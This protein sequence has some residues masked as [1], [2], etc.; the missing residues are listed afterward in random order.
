MEGALLPEGAETVDE[1]LPLRG[2]VAEAGG[3]AEEEGVILSNFVGGYHGD[4]GVFWRGVL[5]G[6]LARG[7][8]DGGAG[9]DHLGEDF[10]GEGLGDL[11]DIGGATS[12]F[13]TCQFGVGERL[14][15]AV[16][17][18]VDDGDLWSHGGWFEGGLCCGRKWAVRMC[19]VAEFKPDQRKK[20]ERRERDRRLAG[21]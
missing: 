8:H 16:H 20:E 17:G 15:V 3:D 6:L 10:L 7:L 9:T 13:D 12:R 4:G 18:V 1:G 11:V 14:D 2:V 21:A 19:W 5:R